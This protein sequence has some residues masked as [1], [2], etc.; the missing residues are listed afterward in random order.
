MIRSM[1]IAVLGSGTRAKVLPTA[2]AEFATP[3]I[4][5]ELVDP[6]LSAFAR[7]A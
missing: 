6:R 2:L 3:D 7:H 4:T 1:R 5:P